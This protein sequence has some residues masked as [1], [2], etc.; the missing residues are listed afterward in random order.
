VKPT[1]YIETSVV[2]Y[3][4][5]KPN[6]DLIIAGRQS[7][8]FKFWAL[9]SFD[10]LPFVS[11]LVLREA[12][13][14]NSVA[15]RNRLFAIQSFSVL[16]ITSEAESLAQKIIDLRGVPQEYPEDALHIAI[17][18]VSRIQF[19]A[20]WNFSHMNNPFTKLAIRRA[21]ERE[22]FDC[23]EIVSPDAF[24]GDES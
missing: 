5:G 8:T 24:L 10:L 1:V 23:P 3:F 17:A 20:T 19:I 15:S 13:K 9:L 16:P 4:V 21:I 7:A 6:K 2:S 12:G 22:G 14:G 11:A 18:A